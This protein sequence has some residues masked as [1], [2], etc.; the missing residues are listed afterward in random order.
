MLHPCGRTVS[1]PEDVKNQPSKTF[2]KALFLISVSKV[3]LH[4][5]YSTDSCLERNPLDLLPHA[6]DLVREL[7]TLVAGDRGRN[8]GTADTAGT[9]E[10]NLRRDV[11]V[12]D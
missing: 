7:A 5:W 10:G 9:A 2:R 6:P 1:A 8:D 4:Y 12:G 11:D 3:A